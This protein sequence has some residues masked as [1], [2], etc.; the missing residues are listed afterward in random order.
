MCYTS[1]ITFSFFRLRT[2]S[3][4]AMVRPPTSLEV[5]YTLCVTC[6]PF[7]LFSREHTKWKT[8]YI[9]KE[10]KFSVKA[11]CY[12]LQ[13]K[14]PVEHVTPEAR[15]YALLCIREKKIVT[16]I[17]RWRKRERERENTPGFN[18]GF[19]YAFAFFCY[20]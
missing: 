3:I 18:I 7:Y 12:G 20:V 11:K 5:H 6:L 1:F 14:H 19:E 9:T 4:I 13:H 16:Q 15:T 2:N 17:D 8:R 10:N